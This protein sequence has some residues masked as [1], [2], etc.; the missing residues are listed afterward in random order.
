MNVGSVVLATDASGAE[1]RGVVMHGPARDRG[2][3]RGSFVKVWLRLD[4]RMDEIP[5]PVES[6]REVTG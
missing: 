3:V 5:W 4:G 6:V 2:G 1:R